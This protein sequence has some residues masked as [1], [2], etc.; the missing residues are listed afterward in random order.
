[1]KNGSG[2]ID[3]LLVEDNPGDRTS[4]LATLKKAN[5]LNRIHALED[6]TRVMDFLFRQGAHSGE[7]PLA[8]E[9]LIL[10]SLNLGGI[11]G[12]DI[13]RRIKADER[14]KSFPVIILSSSQ[15]ER[16]VMQSYKLGANACIVKPIDLRKFIE[17]IAEL[18]L[19]WVLVSSEDPAG[20][21][22]PGD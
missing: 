13:L 12:L 16:G 2:K 15:E 20:G 3:I 4:I 1:M 14:S 11:H 22:L 17:A 8:G 19:G 6:G 5:F 21:K 9:V 18:R 10:L 7:P